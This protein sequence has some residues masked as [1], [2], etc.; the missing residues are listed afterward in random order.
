[1]VGTNPVGVAVPTRG[2]PFVLD[3]STGAVSRGKIL[4]YARDGR[5]LSPGWA[6]DAAGR[7]ATDAGL[8]VDGAISPFGGPKGYALG[9]ALELLVAAV[10]GSELGERVR[11]TLDSTDLCNKGDL[12]MVFAPEV[13]G[14]TGLAERVST[15]LDE[16]RA[17]PRAPG[18]EVIEVPGDR[19]RRMRAERRE[20]GIP[21]ED[22][23]WKAAEEL[24]T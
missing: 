8:A 10:T 23:V 1:M 19:A 7:P 17:S 6:V 15:Y 21:I 13:L 11:G 2:E 5:T 18:A 4:A 20:Y 16:V 22:A 24:L 14:V 12:F 9:I 3:M